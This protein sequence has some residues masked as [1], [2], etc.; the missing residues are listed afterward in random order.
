MIDRRDF[1]TN[2]LR[3]EYSGQYSRGADRR[4][5]TGRLGR[6]SAARRRRAPRRHPVLDGARTRPRPHFTLP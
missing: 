3:C 4:G 5:E 6:G 2:L 1:L